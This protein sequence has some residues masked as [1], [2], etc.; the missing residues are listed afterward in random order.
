MQKNTIGRLLSKRGIAV[1]LLCGIIGIIMLGTGSCQS[2]KEEESAGGIESLD[3]AQYA[4]EVEERVE[5]LCNR[6]DGV[7][8]S[9]AVVSLE[10]GY[11]AIYATDTQS[12]TSSIKKQTVTLGSGSAEKALLLGYE[13]PRIAGI[14]IVCSGGDDPVRRKNVISVISSAFDIPSNKIFVTGS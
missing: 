9:F 11:R 13:N 7:S 2:D 8:S 12:G 1:A 6:V 14:G 10:G 4:R 5:E 3:P